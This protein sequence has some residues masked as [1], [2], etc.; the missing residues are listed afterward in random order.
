MIET[1]AFARAGM[2]GNPSDGYF[3]KTISI[4]VRNFGASITLYESPE[5]H[6]EPQLQD[7]SIYQSVF[8][9]RDTISTLGYHGG[10][11]LIKAAIK[12]FVE[13][14]EGEGIKLHNKNFT[15]R[16][17]TS[18]PRQ[19]GLAGSSAIVVATLRALM[20][21]YKVEIP[22]P[23]LPTLALK[24]ETEELGITAGLQ[25]RV[26][27]CYEG[28]VYMDFAKELIDKQGY[29]YYEP[30]DPRLLP[31][32]YIAYK[33]DLSKVSGK[34]LNTIR[35]RWEAG[36]EHVVNTL[37]SIAGVAETGRDAIKNQDFTQLHQLINQNF[38]YRGQ[39]MTITE[40]NQA[41]IDTARACGASAAF[42]GSG[43]SIIGT[44]RDEEMLNRL[45]VELKKQNARVI[46]P[47]VV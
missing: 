7:E 38:D 39:V 23:Y 26:I 29:G 42:T 1:R 46:K 4:S 10:I 25:D 20:Q 22:L 36:D 44:Y 19:V 12:K 47:F 34:V 30:L 3:G 43:G 32:L 45:F 11:P 17:R 27:Q 16:Y 35:Q 28:C 40:R 33:T 41:M 6:I 5:L 18:I 24:A 9:L 37:K 14:C 31:K 21:F 8:H 15:V 2:L 13:Y